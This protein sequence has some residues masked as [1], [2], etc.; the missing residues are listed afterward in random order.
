MRNGSRK[1]NYFGLACTFHDPALAIVNHE[2]EVAFAEAAERYLQFK[3]GFMCAS[4]TYPRIVDLIEQYCDP[5]A[6]LV[7][8]RSWG[9]WHYL[10]MWIDTWLAANLDFIHPK[11][12]WNWE[13]YYR[14]VYRGRQHAGCVHQ[15]GISI[16]YVADCV[17]PTRKVFRKDW[18]HH[19]C[20]AAASCY[21]CALPEAVVAIIDGFGQYTS[22]AYY[23]YRDGKLKQLPVRQQSWNTLGIYYEFLCRACGFDGDKGEEWKVMGLAPTGRFDQKAYD[24]LKRTVRVDGLRLV[25]LPELYKCPLWSGKHNIPREDLAFT[26]Q[27]LYEEWMTELLGNLR[28]LGISDNLVLGGGCGLNSSYNGLILEKTGFKNLYVFCAPA[29]DGNAVGAALLSYQ[30]DHPNWKPKPEVRS[31]FLGSSVGGESFKNLLRFDRSGLITHHPGQI[32]EVAAKLLAEGQIIGW[33][34]GRAEFGPRA[35]GNRSI[36]ADA[37]D[38][39]IKDRINGRVKFREEFRPFAPSILHEFGP[40]YFENY[41]E[42]PYMERTLRFR[43]E[44]WRKVPGV[45]HVNGTGRLQT[46]KRE[47]NQKYYDLISAF[48]QLTGIPLLLNTSFNI[49][50]KPIIHSV[51][52]AVAVLHTTGLDLLIIDDY[53]IRRPVKA[54]PGVENESLTFR[55]PAVTGASLLA[56]PH[57]TEP[58]R[59]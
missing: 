45:V 30:R 3:R 13:H 23:R 37:R 41:Q 21:S 7:M 53:L 27:Q 47:W 1:R 33:V 56:N 22:T 32:H 34:Q 16:N 8:S 5:D 9:F 26:G 12:K 55:R 36:L 44:V 50:G 4:D 2:G 24:L 15:A 59:Q 46:V 58:W 6:D 20:H 31:P 11:R 18:N 35:L 54:E 10:H 42:S 49:M 17:A 39:N 43:P 48:H 19:L 38:P 14:D 29:D 51:E 28:K 57:G 52:D 40:E 25:D